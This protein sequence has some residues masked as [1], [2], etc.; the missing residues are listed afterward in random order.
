MRKPAP[1]ETDSRSSD[2]VGIPIKGEGQR[3]AWEARGA[4]RRGTGEPRL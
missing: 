3:P 1:G 4:Q 2:N